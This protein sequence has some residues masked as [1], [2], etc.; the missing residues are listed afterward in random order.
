MRK[1]KLQRIAAIFAIARAGNDIYWYH[2]LLLLQWLTLCDLQKL[3]AWC[4]VAS[5][6]KSGLIWK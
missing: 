5:L 2:W 6:P 3:T 4:P 1:T